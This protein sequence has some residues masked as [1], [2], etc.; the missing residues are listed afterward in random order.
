MSNYDIMEK[1]NNDPIY[2]GRL[3]TNY[4]FATQE[5][6]KAGIEVDKEGYQQLKQAYEKLKDGS[7]KAFSGRPCRDTKDTGNDKVVCRITRL[8]N[9]TSNRI[10]ST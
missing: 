8:Y 7:A 6:S 4:E 9:I 1:I 3:F 5:F 2:A 10:Y